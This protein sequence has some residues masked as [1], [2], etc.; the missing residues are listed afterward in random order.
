MD[1]TSRGSEGTFLYYGYGSNL[2]KERIH[3]KNPS[4][5]FVDVAELKDHKLCF[6]GQSKWMS[7]RW[8]GGVATVEERNGSSV[9]G[10]VWRLEE[11]DL[12]S[13]DL[14][15]GEGIVYRRKEV[16]VTSQD[17]TRHTCWTYSMIDFQEGTPSPQYMDVI[18][19]GADQN[20]LPQH[21]LEWLRSIE[22][23]GYSGQVEIM[24]LIDSESSDDTFLYFGYGS[25][26]LKARIHVHN[27]TAQ[28]VG[29][30]KLEG[31]KLCFHAYPDWISYWKGAPATIKKA[32]GDHLWGVVWRLHISDRDHLDSQESGYSVLDVTVTTPEGGSHV[33]R[34]YQ[35]DNDVEEMA[36]SPHYMKVLIEGA[37]QSRVPSSYIQRLEAIPHNGD[38]DPP[39]IMAT[40]FKSTTSQS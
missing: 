4:A 14:Q 40:L 7:N 30:A 22:D 27:P 3:L 15:E 24:N 29:P 28:L 34:T 12:A 26:M 9:W 36:P 35:L 39:P 31:Y 6:G 21:Y 25:N 33:C 1:E 23:N 13:L 18:R 11:K 16:I 2:L 17:G 19:K 8:H 38:K 37:K 10:I 5:V 20:S 32:P